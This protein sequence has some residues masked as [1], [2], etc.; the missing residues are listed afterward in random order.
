[1]I[2]TLMTNGP[3]LGFLLSVTSLATASPRRRPQFLPD[4]ERIATFGGAPKW[5]PWAIVAVLGVA[6]MAFGVLCPDAYIA[7]M[8]EGFTAP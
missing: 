5:V 1:M 7:V 6:S 8:N 3:A 4:N 2:K